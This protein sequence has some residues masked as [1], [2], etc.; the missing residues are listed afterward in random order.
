MSQKKGAC[1]L[2]SQCSTA[3]SIHRGEKKE[4]RRCAWVMSR[5]V[6]SCTVAS[7]CTN[8]C[9]DSA[10]RDGKPNTAHGYLNLS[11]TSPVQIKT[12][13]SNVVAFNHARC[14]DGERETTSCRDW[15]GT[16][17]LSDCLRSMSDTGPS[18]ACRD[19]ICYGA[20]EQGFQVMTVHACFDSKH[21]VF[22]SSKRVRCKTLDSVVFVCPSVVEACLIAE[23]RT[24]CLYD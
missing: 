2:K 23:F 7:F 12:L 15:F 24:D 1:K 21:Q 6:T 5:D 17:I 3:E 9:A 18:V 8:G 13:F 4:R 14:T 10:Q 22:F 16:V 11:L 19:P 20:L